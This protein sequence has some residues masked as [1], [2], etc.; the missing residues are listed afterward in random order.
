MPSNYI[1]IGIEL[2]EHRVELHW[3]LLYIYTARN[4]LIWGFI[5]NCARPCLKIPLLLLVHKTSPAVEFHINFRWTSP[6]PK[7]SRLSA[8]VHA[9]G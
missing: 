1:G 6:I 3:S 7:D 5:C 2:A 9:F 8:G 4:L